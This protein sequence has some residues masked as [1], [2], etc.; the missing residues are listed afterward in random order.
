[1]SESLH[2]SFFTR[3]QAYKVKY[4]VLITNASDQLRNF[5]VLLPVPLSTEYQTVT[6][7]P[8][9]NLTDFK[10]IA[11]KDFG[12]V[13]AIYSGE[14]GAGRNIILRQEFEIE[15]KPRGIAQRLD[16]MDLRECRHINSDN[17]LRGEEKLKFKD[18]AHD[19]EILNKMNDEVISRLNYG[20][21]ISGL[22]TVSEVL[23]RDKVDCGGFDVM[24]ASMALM[25]GYPA[26]ILSGFW[27]GY[28][29]NTMHAWLEVQLPDGRV[30]P[31]DPS[32][33]KLAGEGRS[34]KSGRFG[35]VGSDRIVFS[36]G[37]CLPFIINGQEM[38]VELLQHP[39]LLPHDPDLRYE[40][41]VKVEIL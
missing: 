4:E 29:N 13:A 19:L 20:N 33:Q 18:E 17:D 1:M 3:K 16:R 15:V 5:Q 27:A 23:K 6:K 41:D 38:T 32:V 14:V 24:L 40:L 35:F 8:T 9:F 25:K 10:L 22:Y 11:D 37:C 34:R 31:L 36:R 2:L 39:F 26:R 28:D 12:N 7:Q 30:V 21:A